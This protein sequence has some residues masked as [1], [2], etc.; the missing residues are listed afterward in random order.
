MF[1]SICCFCYVLTLAY[2]LDICI[3][4]SSSVLNNLPSFARFNNVNSDK[5]MLQ[6]RHHFPDILSLQKYYLHSK[7]RLDLIFST[8][9]M[10]YIFTSFLSSSLNFSLMRT[11]PR[12]IPIL[13]SA[14]RKHFCHLASSIVAPVVSFS[15]LKNSF[16]I[17]LGK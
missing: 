6:I 7:L 11:A 2:M 3:L 5:N 14:L 4:A 8:F 9:Q 12:A 15:M 16:V 1:L 17:V 10:F 13:D